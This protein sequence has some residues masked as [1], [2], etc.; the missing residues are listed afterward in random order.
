MEWLQKLLG[1]TP[2]KPSVTAT[3]RREADGVY[4]LWIG[5]VLNKATLD[6]IQAM[7]RR[8]IEAGARNLKVLLFLDDFRGWKRG[9]DWG[10][11]D[12]FSRYEEHISKI[13]VVGEERWKEETLLFLGAGRR[14]GE[15]RYFQKHFEGQAKAWLVQ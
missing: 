11:L 13:A 7:A 5:G 1:K 8:D 14:H 9:D 2:S 6:N 3:F 12:F 15:V 4:S 10:D